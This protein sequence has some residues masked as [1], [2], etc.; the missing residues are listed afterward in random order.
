M[1]GVLQKTSSE[2]A[3]QSNLG[4][5]ANLSTGE[6]SSTQAT[7]TLTKTDSQDMAKTSSVPPVRDRQELQSHSSHSSTNINETELSQEC[8]S[9]IPINQSLESN[10]ENEQISIENCKHASENTNKLPENPGRKTVERRPSNKL[11][12]ADTIPANISHANNIC[13]M[14]SGKKRSYDGNSTS[15][16][17]VTVNVSPKRYPKRRRLNQHEINHNENLSDKENSDSV[18][19]EFDPSTQKGSV[20]KSTV[21]GRSCDPISGIANN[22]VGATMSGVATTSS[23]VATRM[24]GVATTTS[25]VSTTMSGVATTSSGVATSSIAANINVN[26]TSGVSTNTGAVANTELGCSPY[27]HVKRVAVNGQNTIPKVPAVPPLPPSA[28]TLNAF[29]TLLTLR[30]DLQ[31]RA[32]RVETSLFTN[33]ESE[34]AVQQHSGENVHFRNSQKPG[35]DS[36]LLLANSKQTSFVDYRNMS[37]Y[38]QLLNRFKGLFMWPGFL[39][40]VNPSIS[41]VSGEKPKKN[42]KRRTNKC[43]NSRIS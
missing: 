23:G 5:S 12:K 38:Q 39:S 28:T 16:G 22:I 25:G 11:D 21:I 30:K 19:T 14:K 18:M 40:L 6:T 32:N 24:S 20:R 10:N 13:Q 33:N 41:K 7:S 35:D 8:S 34:T 26:K 2:T 37:A 36:L 1:S 15:S 27:F 29:K 43:L 4:L 3:Q 17:D 9:S 42:K 31:M